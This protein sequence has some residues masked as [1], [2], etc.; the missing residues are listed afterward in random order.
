MVILIGTTVFLYQA[1]W[2]TSGTEAIEVV[3]LD[4]Y[5]KELVVIW[6]FC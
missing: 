6:V 3:G 1:I 2:T 5:Q 4:N